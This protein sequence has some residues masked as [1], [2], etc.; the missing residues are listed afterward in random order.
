MGIYED[1][2][3]AIHVARAMIKSG[4]SFVYYLGQALEHAD[5]INTARIK[6]AF[7][8]YWQEYKAMAGVD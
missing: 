7:P 1:H 4:G 3:E 2:D 5:H 8:E 6:D